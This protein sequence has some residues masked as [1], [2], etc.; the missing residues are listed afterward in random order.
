[1]KNKESIMGDLIVQARWVV[2][3][4]ADR[5]TPVVIDQGAVLSKDGL[6]RPPARSTR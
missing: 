4:T 1:V 2:T 5:H 3:G 6:V